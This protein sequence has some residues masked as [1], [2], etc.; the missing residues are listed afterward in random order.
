MDPVKWIGGG[1]IVLIIYVIVSNTIWLLLGSRFLQF[2][3]GIDIKGFRGT[4]LIAT[5]LVLAGMAIGI[6]LFRWPLSKIGLLSTLTIQTEIQTWV[7]RG[8]V[9]VSRRTNRFKVSK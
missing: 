3:P 4:L 8:S 2:L 1:L 7:R 6:W 5:M 9:F